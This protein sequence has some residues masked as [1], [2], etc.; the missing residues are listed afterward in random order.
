[1]Q[2]IQ[3][4]ASV[5][6]TVLREGGANYSKWFFDEQA[7]FPDFV[8]LRYFGSSPFKGGVHDYF[9]YFEVHLHPEKKGGTFYVCT[10]E[11][12][13]TFVRSM[14]SQSHA[15]IFDNSIALAFETRSEKHHLD[16]R[17][18]IDRRGDGC[19]SGIG[20]VEYSLTL[21]HPGTKESTKNINVRETPVIKRTEITCPKCLGQGQFNGMS[22]PEEEHKRGL[23]GYALYSENKVCSHT[24]CPM[25]GGSGMSYED[26]F[27]K[28][29]E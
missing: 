5:C 17:L 20:V 7:N 3:Q 9:V 19:V 16:G 15:Q 10:L 2:A 29:K 14:P 11:V 28:E 18:A 1:M 23:S 4:Y 25:C 22:I 13:P 21:I 6:R 27:I 24:G 12:G 26:W 8:F